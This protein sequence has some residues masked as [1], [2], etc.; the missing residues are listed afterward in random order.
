[1]SGPGDRGAA[2]R[3]PAEALLAAVGKSL[4]VQVLFPGGVRDDLRCVRPDY[5][6]AIGGAAIGYVELKSPGRVIDPSHF[7]GHEQILWDRH[8]DLPNLLYSNGL[9]WRLYRDGELAGQAVSLHADS[10]ESAGSALEA[11]P[12][13]EKLLT[14]FL[15]WT[16]APIVSV[17]A[18]VR[19]IAPLTRLLRGEV[20][21]QL[22]S[23]RRAI[24]SG[25]EMRSHAFLTL[26]QDWHALLFPQA[27]DAIFA[28]GYAQA[29]TFA[30]LLARTEGIDV[31]MTPLHQVGTRLGSDHSMMGRALQLLTGDVA[32]GFKVTLD[33]LVRVIGAVDWPRVRRGRR[34]TY[35]HLYEHFLELYDNTLRKASGSYYTP[36]QVVDPMVR[37]AEEAL[38]SRLGKPEGFRDPA[39]ITVD[40][41]MGTGT[42]LQTVLERVADSANSKDGPGA[43]ADAVRCAAGRLAGFELQVGPFAV[44]EL[45]IAD[46]MASHGAAPPDGG[47]RLY[48]TD[49]LDDPYAAQVN[50]IQAREAVTVVLGNPPYAE[51]AG[52][53]GGWIERGD[54][55]RGLRPP[56]DAFRTRGDGVYIQNLKNLYVYFWRWGT[57]KAW[58][59]APARPPA[60]A[61][62][63]CFIS[64]SG[65]VRGP[66][67]RGMR[68]YLR[69]YAAE[70]WIIDLTPEGQTPDVPTRIFPGVRQPLAI[71]LFVRTSE[72]DPR[73][74]AIMHYRAVA[75]RQADKF[76]ALAS[77]TLDDAGW[78]PVRTEWS[79]PLT[80]AAGDSW[81]TYPALSDI[82]PWTTPGV[83]PNRTWVYDPS[84][85]V[86]RI[87]WGRLVGENNLAAKRE[88]FRES[89]DA[90]LDKSPEPLPGPDT[91]KF[92]GAFARE[93]ASSPAPIRVG[94]RSFDRQ[95]LIPDAR[96]MHAPRRPLWAARIA[97]QVFIVEQ[98]SK[99]IAK[100]P[101]VVFSA[102][103]PDMDYFKGSEGG[104]TLPLLQPDGSP[105]LAPGLLRS[106]GRHLGSEI[107]AYDIVAYLAAVAAH[108][109]FQ[110]TFADA[111]RT[112][113]V[114]VPVTK[115]ADLWAEA[116]SIG[117]HVI[118]AHTYGACFADAGSGR[119]ELNVRFPK[120]DPRQPLALKAMTSLPDSIS[121]D[122][123]TQTMRLGAGEWGP[124]IPEAWAFTVDGKSVL[125][126]WYNYR[127][128]CPG[129]RK[130]SPLDETHPIAWQS[131][132]TTEL[133]DLL[134]VLTRL[135]ELQP[136]Q[137]DLLA[138]VTSGETFSVADLRADQVRWPIS[139]QDR[140]PRY[141]VARP[142]RGGPPRADRAT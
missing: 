29:V 31:A 108:P 138:R 116:V 14:E 15:R 20:I 44:A 91:H 68:Q 36:H 140:T 51:N 52:G 27:A 17:A 131:N 124:V 120:G 78:R 89:R 57:W 26:A 102:L 43:V 22:A 90:T 119:P 70:G 110:Q 141:A 40:P 94:Y 53:K 71:G 61:G 87:R 133:T 67:F 2:I 7:T 28:D 74:P 33:L 118:W 73:S 6:A 85:E 32:A 83:T 41:A 111:L 59:S 134:T 34:D 82:F 80:P 93:S 18:L 11:A 137:S 101:S 38:I 13:L 46:L 58:E 92:T 65:Y 21:D 117:E 50:E 103:I 104:R 99:M 69:R 121:Y 113:G 142:G 16:P 64:T 106:I 95:W 130:S 76:E 5:G 123:S 3:S 62:I 128:A 97:G 88:L 10:L 79:A 139:K 81:D 1:M 9:D 47:M 63:I 60:G 66:G 107:S 98:H 55:G 8:K 122:A 84:P 136:G 49:T 45:R 19:A 109:A 114:R 132:W 100:G 127:K 72:T 12:E 56:L 126:S 86:L 77:M 96:L 24:R 105:N 75:G 135:V 37:L 125:K 35:L 42:Y 30:L 129:G 54:S 115:D 112:P 4:G 23:E 25:A 39:V 48:R